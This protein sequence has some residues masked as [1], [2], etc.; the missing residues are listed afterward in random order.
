MDLGK[1]TGIFR[2]ISIALYIVIIIITM[3]IGV[4]ALYLAV[5]SVLSL[6]TS[7]VVTDV[8]IFNV[9]SSV[10][11]VV[12]ALEFVD[13]FVEYIKT[14]GVVVS[15]VIAIVLTALSRE[16]ILYIAEPTEPAYYGYLL[17]ASIMVLAVA[18]WLVSRVGKA[19]TK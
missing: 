19:V 18:Y 4:F 13:M 14:G 10:F 11:I 8:E 5:K 1:L 17:I 2:N 9:L 16:L 6:L 12:I 15:L 7:K 3:V